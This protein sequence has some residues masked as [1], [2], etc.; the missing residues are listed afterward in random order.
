MQGIQERGSQLRPLNQAKNDRIRST[1]RANTKCSIRF[2]KSR[3]TVNF[4]GHNSP[5]PKRLRPQRLW[6][7]HLWM[8]VAT[9]RDF[10]EFEPIRSLRWLQSM[11]QLWPLHSAVNNIESARNKLSMWQWSQKWGHVLTGGSRIGTG[12]GSCLRKPNSKSGQKM[13]WLPNW[14]WGIYLTF[15][16]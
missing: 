10:V 9:W 8:G 7:R 3:T 11:R 5:I 4:F 16:E 1:E 15:K 6:C 13:S 12:S 14:Y 2:I